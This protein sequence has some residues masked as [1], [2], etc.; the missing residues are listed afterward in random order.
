MDPYLLHALID[1]VFSAA[2]FALSLYILLIAYSLGH[3]ELPYVP[4]NW[5]ARKKLKEV[6]TQH[7][8]MS[9]KDTVL[10][11]GSGLGM[12]LVFFSQF[13]VKITGIEQRKSLA[14]LSKIRLA[15]LHPFKKGT[16]D[17]ITGSFFDIPLKDYSII[18]CFHINKIVERLRPK[19]EAELTKKQILISYQFPHKLSPE[20][21]SEEIIEVEKKSTIYIYRR[22]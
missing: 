6:L 21:F 18:Y 17:V 16:V 4:T 9:E 8:T 3:W 12:M 13:P 20:K 2:I 1:L 15:L 19:L 11:M 14:W 22:K 5:K 10:D 7:H